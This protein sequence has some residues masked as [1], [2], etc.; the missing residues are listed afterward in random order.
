MNDNRLDKLSDL[1][2]PS[3]ET[4]NFL[5]QLLSQSQSQQSLQHLAEAMG[6]PSGNAPL[7]GFR[8][9]LIA[10]KQ[11]YHQP[12]PNKLCLK[13]VSLYRWEICNIQLKNADLSNSHLSETKWT[14]VSWEG[15]SLADATLTQSSWNDCYLASITTERMSSES[16]IFRNCTIRDLKD[17]GGWCT[18]YHG[19]ED[20]K[21]DIPQP[22]L[23]PIREGHRNS[24]WSVVYDGDRKRYISG[25][26]DKTLKVWDAETHQCIATH[27]LLPDNQWAAFESKLPRAVVRSENSGEHLKWVGREAETGNLLAIP[28][29]GLI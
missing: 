18:E 23:R 15:G 22:F 2:L 28:F 5:G 20:M 25:S 14:N 16:A 9:M 21:A 1:P 6:R 17:V 13:G 27:L 12:R 24:V 8:Y 26:V 10:A 3:D 29:E 19:T 11:G 4:L 7:I